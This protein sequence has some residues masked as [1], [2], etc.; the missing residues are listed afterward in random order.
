MVG[1]IILEY[2]STQVEEISA[3]NSKPDLDGTKNLSLNYNTE[4]FLSDNL[5][6]KGTGYLRKLTLD[7][8]YLQMNRQK[9]KILCMLFSQA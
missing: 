2:G 5:K 3:G 9:V 8:I 4:K 1:I 7:M 6:F